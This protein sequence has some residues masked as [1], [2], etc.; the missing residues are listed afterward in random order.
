MV[1]SPRL[2][3]GVRVE[4]PVAT[5][6]VLPTIAELVGLRAPIWA[7]GESLVPYI[8]GKQ[9]QSTGAKF[10]FIDSGYKIGILKDGYRAIYD[11]ISRKVLSLEKV[12][13]FRTEKLDL[14]EE[15][16]KAIAQSLTATIKAKFG[17]A[18]W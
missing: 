13:R 5:V 16:N 7:Q 14:R 15:K 12:Y 4:T 10:V 11:L 9:G 2:P 1:C 3:Q 6:D 18:R 17:Q 8:S